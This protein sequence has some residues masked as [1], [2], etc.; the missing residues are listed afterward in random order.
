MNRRSSSAVIFLLVEACLWILYIFQ[1]EMANYGIYTLVSYNAHEI[2]SVL[3]F[4]CILASAVWLLVVTIKSVRAKT[5]KAHAIV[6]SLLAV[7]VCVQA[8]Y[9]S[10][11]SDRI[12]I[13]VAAS[14]ERI[15]PTKKE[16]VINNAGER[17]S[18]EC[19]MTIFELLKIDETYLISYQCRK[20]DP[21]VGKVSLIQ[22]IEN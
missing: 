18:L 7:A 19:P 12:D 11:R 3:P 4:I 6:I 13:S 1:E 17:V 21:H 22:T 5:F 16:I 14:V 10:S 9:L 2:L 15:D 20:D 8:G